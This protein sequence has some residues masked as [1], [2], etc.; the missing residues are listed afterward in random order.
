MS[1]PRIYV[2]MD[3]VLC[4]YNEAKYRTLLRTP[5]NGFPQASYGFFRDMK[6][7][8]GALK[9]YM[10]LH[11][12]FDTW[13]LT[14]PSVLN[15]MCYTEKREWVEKHLG[16][17]ICEKLIMCC[18]KG[19]LKGDYLIDDMSWP[20]FEGKQITFGS[21]EYP[22][23]F[24]VLAFF[25]TLKDNGGIAQ[26]DLERSGSGRA[27]G[28]KTDESL[29]RIHASP[30]ND[31]EEI[32][33]FSSREE[34]KQELIRCASDPKYFMEKYGAVKVEKNTPQ[35]PK[36][37]EQKIVE[38]DGKRYLVAWEHTYIGDLGYAEEGVFGLERLFRMDT[39]SFAPA[40]NY[41][42]KVIGEVV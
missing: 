32:V 11:E 21:K 20:L 29:V 25:M 41:T 10:W 15:P 36:D 1:K 40:Y 9:A 5:E 34:L 37:H 27:V 14:R 13:I 42:W 23:W 24:E 28:L 39:H 26:G 18:E 2:D 12:N 31:E 33:T 16:I 3:G 4:D 6:P 7:I 8:D 17:E 19:L 35:E 22:E 30:T 38:V